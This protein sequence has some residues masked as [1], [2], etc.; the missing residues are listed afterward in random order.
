LQRQT[1]LENISLALLPDSLIR[2]A[3]DPHVA[4]RA[5]EIAER[6]G[7]GAV[8]DRRPGT[9]PFADLRRLELAK[10]IA[11]DPRV[12]LVDEP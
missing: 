11:R 5:K 2:L 8:V 1:V 7:L 3:A 12:V 10:A 9:L 4:R 6:V